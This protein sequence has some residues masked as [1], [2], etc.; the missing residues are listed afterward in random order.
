MWSGR[1]LT[2]YQFPLLAVRR[3]RCGGVVRLGGGA[4]SKRGTIELSSSW[5]REVR[6]RPGAGV[7]CGCCLCFRRS[8]GTICRVSVF[9]EVRSTGVADCRRFSL[10]WGAGQ[11]EAR[12]VLKGCPMMTPSPMAHKMPST[13]SHRTLRRC[14]MACRTP[15]SIQRGRPRRSPPSAELCHAGVGRL[16]R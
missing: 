11:T 16:T 1:P 8:V 5:R 3:P 2:G 15:L 7:F 13:T 9:T 4:G 6:P 14:W 12:E 10:G